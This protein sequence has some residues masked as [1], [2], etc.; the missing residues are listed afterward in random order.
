ML[1]DAGGRTQVA[2]QFTRAALSSCSRE[3]QD[4]VER[5]LRAGRELADELAMILIRTAAVLIRGHHA[6]ADL[7]LANSNLLASSAPVR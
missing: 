1:F 3:A 6:G 2:R 5:R 4:E 7:H